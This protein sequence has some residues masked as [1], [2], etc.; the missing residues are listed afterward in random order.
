MWKSI[1]SNFLTLSILG[2]ILLGG[3]IGWG[4]TA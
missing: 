3:L 4:Q 2:L 1:A